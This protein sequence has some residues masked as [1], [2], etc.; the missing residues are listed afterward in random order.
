MI[1]TPIDNSL[2]K[3]RVRILNQQV[4][5]CDHMDIPDSEETVITSYRWET[6]YVTRPGIILL[7]V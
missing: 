4:N 3:V 1:Y 2:F 6:N 5:T 7:S